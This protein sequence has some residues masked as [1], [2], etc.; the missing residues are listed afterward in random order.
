MQEVLD[1]YLPMDS[2]IGSDT[3]NIDKNVRDSEVRFV[4]FNERTQFLKD[5]LIETA[6]EDKFWFPREFKNRFE[7]T[8]SEL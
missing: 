6:D 2:F 3:R 5:W 1:T 7:R 8:S 4:Q